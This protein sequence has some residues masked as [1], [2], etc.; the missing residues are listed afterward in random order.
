MFTEPLLC[1]HKQYVT[2]RTLK[3]RQGPFSILLKVTESIVLCEGSVGTS[4]RIS[5]KT[6]RVEMELHL[7]AWI[8]LELEL[9][10]GLVKKFTVKKVI[11]FLLFL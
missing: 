11:K 1:P 10:P 8:T 6:L 4:R 3:E 7:T 9:N 5:L 2:I